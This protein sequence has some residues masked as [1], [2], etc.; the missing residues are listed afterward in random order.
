METDNE[1]RLRLRFFK[2]VE[3]NIDVVRQKFV[4]YAKNLPSGFLIKIRPNHIQFTIQGEK[5]KYWSPHLSIE[6]EE[7][8]G[9]EKNAT[10]IRGLFGPAQT[11]WTFFMFLHFLVAGIFTLFGMFAYSNYTLKEPMMM[12]LVIMF[13]MVIVWF[14][15]YVIARQLRERGH[16]QMNDLENEFEKIITS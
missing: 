16:D 12:D 1:I 2:D 4:D 5:Q 15:L 13:I 9:N 11:L 7:K 14:L 10:H 8:E 3:E 6:L